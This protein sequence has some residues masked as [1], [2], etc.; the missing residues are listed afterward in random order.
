LIFHSYKFF[1]G[2]QVSFGGEV[3]PVLELPPDESYERFGVD[4]S[5]FAGMT[6]ELRFTGLGSGLFDDVRFSTV[7]IPEPGPFSLAVTGVTLLAIA[8]LKLMR[9]YGGAEDYGQQIL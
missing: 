8:Q 3:L 5:R 1:H 7:A 6:G 4:I 2:V 9:R